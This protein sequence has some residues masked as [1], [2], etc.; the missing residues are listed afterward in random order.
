MISLYVYGIDNI[1]W[2]HLI[3]MEAEH[4]FQWNPYDFTGIGE[5]FVDSVGFKGN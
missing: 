4:C 5:I 1:Y 2:N 3:V